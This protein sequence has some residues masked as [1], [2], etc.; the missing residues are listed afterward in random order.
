[1]G[2]NV[3]MFQPGWVLSTSPS[4]TESAPSLSPSAG[5]PHLAIRCNIQFWTFSITVPSPHPV[6]IRSDYH[7]IMLNRISSQK[8]AAIHCQTTSHVH[9]R[10]QLRGNRMSQSFREASGASFKRGHTQHAIS[11]TASNPARAL[12]WVWLHALLHTMTTVCYRYCASNQ[13]FIHLQSSCNLL[14]PTDVVLEKWP[15]GCYF[16]RSIYMILSTWRSSLVFLGS[17]S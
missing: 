16:P 15:S 17:V 11:R 2:F 5:D 12:P 4:V 9:L 6:T 8:S 10:K 7:Q 3:S 14:W 1:M 13:H